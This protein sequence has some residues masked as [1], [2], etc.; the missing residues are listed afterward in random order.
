ME[1]DLRGSA[2][3]EQ[4]FLVRMHIPSDMFYVTVKDRGR[5]ASKNALM[6]FAAATY[7]PVG[8]AMPTRCTMRG[9]L[10]G[11]GRADTSR[12]IE[13]RE[14]VSQRIERRHQASEFRRRGLRLNGPSMFELRLSMISAE[15]RP[16][17]WMGWQRFWVMPAS[18]C[19]RIHGNSSYGVAA[20]GHRQPRPRHRGRPLRRTVIDRHRQLAARKRSGRCRFCMQLTAAGNGPRGRFTVCNAGAHRRLTCREPNASFIPFPLPH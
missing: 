16:A 11:Q 14:F 3:T 20:L 1:K 7:Q 6:C 2:E 13:A 15:I 10:L 9:V 19:A 17:P 18:A 5:L 4:L 8:S 12:F